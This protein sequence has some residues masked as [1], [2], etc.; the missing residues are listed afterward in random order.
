MKFLKKG[1]VNVMLPAAL[2]LYV[3]YLVYRFFS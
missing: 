2:L 1:L 3:A